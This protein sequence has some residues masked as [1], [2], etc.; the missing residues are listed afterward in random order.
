MDARDL[1]KILAQ[2]IPMAAAMRV[3]VVVA[4][5][6]R[7]DLRC[8][9]GP[10]H[11]HLGTAFGGSL[12]TLMILSAYCRLF[13]LMGGQGHVLLK[14]SRM[15]FLVPVRED[16][17]AVCLKPE[18]LAADAFRNAYQKKG[19][20]R[21][22]LSAQILLADGT[23]AARMVGEFVGRPSETPKLGDGGAP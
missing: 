9:L 1:E 14:S 21:L 8:P 16:L 3:C 13:Q 17:T 7:V 19:R 18:K 12:S 15:E 23:I 22:E 2:Q 4:D 11:N 5:D 10:N 20:A 6:D